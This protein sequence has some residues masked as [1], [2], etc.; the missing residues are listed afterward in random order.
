MKS[1]LIAAT[2]VFLAA[3]ATLS[4][5]SAATPSAANSAGITTRTPHYEWQYQYDRKGRFEGHWVLVR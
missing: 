3:T 1:L 4:P 5:A 2:A